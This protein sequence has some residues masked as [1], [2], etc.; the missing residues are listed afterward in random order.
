ML[1]VQT[2]AISESW[3]INFVAFGKR[4][5]VVRKRAVGFIKLAKILGKRVR[6]HRWIG[7]VKKYAELG[8]LQSQE[9]FPILDF[10]TSGLVNGEPAEGWPNSRIACLLN[11]PLISWT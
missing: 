7:P 11:F 4:V 1:K 8:A 9:E 10:F 6:E 2:P 5:E 3:M